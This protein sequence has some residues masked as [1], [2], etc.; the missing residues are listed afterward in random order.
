MVVKEGFRKRH[1]GYDIGTC[2]MGSDFSDSGVDK[3][4]RARRAEPFRLRRL[5]LPT[6]TA[7]NPSLTIEAIAARTADRIREMTR[8]GQLK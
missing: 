5:S 1:Q 3:N 4:C 7:V 2:R 8:R 6:S